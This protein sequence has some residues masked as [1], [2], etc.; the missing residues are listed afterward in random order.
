M[1]FFHFELEAFHYAARC[2][3]SVVLLRAGSDTYASLSPEASLAF[4]YAL[5]HRFFRKNGLFVP[6]LE[7]VE[8]QTS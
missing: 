6:V 8:S 5:K 1:N 4:S 7:G 3:G 2:G